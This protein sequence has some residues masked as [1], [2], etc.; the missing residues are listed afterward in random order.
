MPQKCDDHQ[1]RQNRVRR[2]ERSRHP[3]RSECA[4]R[5]RR[6]AETRRIPTSPGGADNSSAREETGEVTTYRYRRRREKKDAFMRR[7]VVEI[8]G[9]EAGRLPAIGKQ[10]QRALP[11]RD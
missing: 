6:Q 9:E 10:L 7:V 8:C 1:A 3:H 11:F 5:T 4:Q 2:P